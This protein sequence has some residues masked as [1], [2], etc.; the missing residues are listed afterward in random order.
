MRKNEVITYLK[1]INIAL[2]CIT[3]F[4]FPVLF[5]TITTDPYILPKQIFLVIISSVILLIWSVISIYQR[6][7]IIKNNPFNVPLGIFTLIL[8]ISSV[9]SRN[10]YDSLAISIPVVSLFIIVFVMVNTI[11]E[12]KEF[13]AII[14][15]LLIGAAGSTIIS[16]LNNFQ[17]YFLPVPAAQ[18]RYF[19]TFGSPVQHVMYILPLFIMAVFALL[20]EVRAKRIKN[21]YE[22]IFYI[23]TGAIFL[24]GL[25]VILFQIA[26]VAQKP[27]LLPY[28]YGFQI[29]TAAV[30]QDTGVQRILVFDIPRLLISLPFGSGYGTFFTDYTRFRLIDINSNNTLWNFPFTYSSSFALELL[31]TA[32]ILGLL[33]YFYL[34]ARILKT[35]SNAATP[36]FLALLTVLALSFFLPFSLSTLFLLFILIGIY[37]TFLCLSHDKRTEVVS[38]S[39]FTSKEF[40]SIEEVSEN[41]RSTKSES[42]VLPVLITVVVAVVFGVISYLSLMLLLAD[43]KIV[44]SLSQ[45]NQTNGQKVYDLQRKALIEFPYRSDYY[46]IFSQ[47]NLNL[48]NS[49]ANTVPEGSSPSAQVQQTVAQLLQQSV[50]N[51]RTAVAL[52]PLTAVNWENL[53]QIYRNL[54]GAG[55]N[56][57]QFAVAS[58]NQAILLDPSN[59][60]LRI[61]LGGIFYQLQNFDAAQNQ[62]QIAVNLKPDFANAYYNLGHTLEQKG[63]LKNALTAYQ[64]TL[65]LV[66]NDEA[67]KK[68][69]ETEIDTISKKIGQ[70]PVQSGEALPSGTAQN[71]PPLELNTASPVPAQKNQV[72][73][74]PPPGTS[75]TPT[76]GPSPT[77]QE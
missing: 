50:G 19:S 16:I 1:K 32:G 41:S 69:L 68:Q 14:A 21:N 6:K 24:I 34:I 4:L 22:G 5:L 54:I 13:I 44:S 57:D 33:S 73:V 48:A 11:N 61:E 45:A 43:T 31:A 29:G 56:A 8:L 72:K 38:V 55:Q 58:F 17:F 7:I 2:I 10:I 25:A 49:I 53:G 26:T 18:S 46:R 63:D 62:F 52:S 75:A 74:P 77:P 47:V 70:S 3:L 71:Q 30:T 20:G 23:A 35:R 59:P 36:I 51:A 15:S 42:L 40:F 39:L 76:E 27:V 28:T 67:S 65:S 66:Q 37:S 12:K 60:L 64:A 9:L